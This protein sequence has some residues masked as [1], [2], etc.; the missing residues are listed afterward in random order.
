MIVRV[1]LGGTRLQ[2]ETK[3]VSRDTLGKAVLD[4]CPILPYIDRLREEP[5]AKLIRDAGEKHGGN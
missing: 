5:R 3:R 2:A 1:L 4:A